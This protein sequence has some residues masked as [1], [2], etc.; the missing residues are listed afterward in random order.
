MFGNLDKYL[1]VFL[2]GLVVT[3]LLTPW[4]RSLAVKYGVV[5]VPNERRPHKHATARGGGLALVIGT[6]AAFLA[7][8][9]FPW[10]DL[11][12]ALHIPWWHPFTLASPVLVA[13]GVGDDV[14]ALPRYDLQLYVRNLP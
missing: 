2:T 11:A 8:I 4:A 7:A 6:H 14:Q 9:A 5:D 13:V 3:Y 12:G 10:A 1:F